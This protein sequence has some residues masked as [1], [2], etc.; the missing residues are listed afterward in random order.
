VAWI[1]PNVEQRV[2]DELA[3][4]ESMGHQQ[5]ARNALSALALLFAGNQEMVRAFVDEIQRREDP[6]NEEPINAYVAE[7][8]A[9][10]AFVRGDRTAAEQVRAYAQKRIQPRGRIWIPTEI[11]LSNLGAPLPADGVKAQ[12]LEPYS[13]VEERWLE[14]ATQIRLRAIGRDDAQKA[15]H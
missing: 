8:L 3:I 9:L 14:L 2:R 10:D 11:L 5:G 6:S 13:T 12:W 7:P 1:D 4:C 15:Q